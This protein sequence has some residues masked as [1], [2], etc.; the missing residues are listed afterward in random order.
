MRRLIA[1]IALAVSSLIAIGVGINPIMSQGVNNLDFR[2][3]RQF[4]YQ[5]FDRTDSELAIEEEDAAKSVAQTMDE[6][7]K[8]WGVSNYKVEIE[9][10]DIVRVSLTAKNDTEY[11]YLQKYLGFSGQD[12]SIATKDEQIRLTHEEVFADSEAY[13]VYEG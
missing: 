6:R 2:D 9:G 1:Y 11:D 3:G 7:L 13:I 8:T 4:V 10:N 5:L 12:F